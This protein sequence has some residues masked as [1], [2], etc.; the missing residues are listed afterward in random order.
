MRFECH[1][2]EREPEPRAVAFRREVRLEDPLPH[3]GGNTRPVVRDRHGESR[4]VACDR[5][6][7]RAGA[8]HRFGG[9]AIEVRERPAQRLVVAHNRA[10]SAVRGEPD[11][12]TIGNARP[13][14]LLEQ[15][16]EIDFAGRP[17][18]QSPE[19][20]EFSRESLQP[21]GF[22]RHHLHGRFFPTFR[23]SVLPPQL[24]HR[25]PHR[26]QR[27]LDLMRDAARDF[28]ERPQSLGL[29]LA[30]ARRGESGRQ[31]AQRL[32]Q[33]FEFGRAAAERAT[34]GGKGLV[35]PDQGGPTHQLVD[36][37]RELPRQ[38]PGQI[39]G[40]VQ[41]AGAE[42]QD[43]HR[44]SGRVV[45][46]ECFGA[47]GEADG[48]RDFVEVLAQQRA[49]V[50]GEV[51]RIDALEQC[52]RGRGDALGGRAGTGRGQEPPHRH[53]PAGDGEQRRHGRHHDEDHEDSP[54]EWKRH[55][56]RQFRDLARL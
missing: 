4:A 13:S 35:A 14:Q 29:E 9:V 36:R 8:L 24:I 23:H 56:A 22:G 51:Q 19:I 43:D 48:S 39:H 20:S 49:L 38:M 30:F 41:H 46:Q 5:H 26:R 47:A 6:V 10:R 17:F 50:D 27:I 45:A 3:V 40:G 34:G 53:E 7:E 2:H 31:F 15:L 52:S 32:A 25:D 33:R 16:H 54:S 11:G 37:A 12:N 28:A 44:D 55:I 18:R 21:I 42:E 1:P